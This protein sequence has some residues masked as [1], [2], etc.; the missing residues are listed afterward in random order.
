MDQSVTFA[1]S[2]FLA[3]NEKSSLA[4]AHW[5]FTTRRAN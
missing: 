4:S 3:G 5:T 2:A 1:S